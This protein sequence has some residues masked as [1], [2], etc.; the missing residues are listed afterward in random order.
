MIKVNQLLQ[1]GEWVYSL[2]TVGSFGAPS[3]EQV[4][5]DEIPLQLLMNRDLVHN[6]R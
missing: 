3:T 6:S 5:E 1:D 2:E 4:Q